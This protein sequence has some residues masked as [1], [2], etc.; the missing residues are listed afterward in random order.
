MASALQNLSA[1]GKREIPSAKGMHFVILVSEWNTEI[2][3]ALEKAAHVTLIKHGA[4]PKNI[5]VEYVPGSFE[6]PLGAQFAA[7]LH[8]TDA[9][10]C[11]G[12]IIQ[13]ETRHFEF[14]SHAVGNGITNVGLMYNKPVVFGVLTTDTLKQAKDRTGGKHGNKGDEAALT[15]IKMVALKKNMKN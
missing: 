9:V 5:R 12:C 13:G 8:D 11:L 15:A 14:I 6:L 1:T 7:Q 10:I 4:K 2:T 3:S